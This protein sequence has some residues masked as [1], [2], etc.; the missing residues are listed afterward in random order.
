MQVL[1]N[2]EGSIHHNAMTVQNGIAVQK[3]FL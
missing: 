2:W 1:A 3:L